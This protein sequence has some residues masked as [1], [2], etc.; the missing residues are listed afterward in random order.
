MWCPKRIDGPVII[1]MMRDERADAN[2]LVVDVFRE[3]IAHGPA[4]LIGRFAE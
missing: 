2:N 1:L 3:F 4:H